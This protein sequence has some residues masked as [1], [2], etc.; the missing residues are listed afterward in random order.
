MALKIDPE[1]ASGYRGLAL[2]LNEIGRLREALPAYLKAVTLNPSYDAWFGGFRPWSVDRRAVRR[3]AQVRHCGRVSSILTPGA[4]GYHLGVALVLLD[5]DARFGALSHGSGG[6]L[7]ERQPPADAAGVRWTCDGDGRR[8]RSTESAPRQ[9]RRRTTSRSCSRA[10]RSGR[11]P[12]RLMHPTMSR[13]SSS[14]QPTV[15]LHTA[16]YPVKLAHAY[17]LHRRGASAGARKIVDRT[18]RDQP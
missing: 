14:A 18:P 4:A 8:R 12:V 2:N 15:S 11:L 7:S 9:R 13:R 5:D 1:L 17:H 10:R 16:P 3:V 6:A